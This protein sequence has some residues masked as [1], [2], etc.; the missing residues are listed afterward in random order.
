MDDGTGGGLALIPE[1]APFDEREA[2]VA[3]PPAVSKVL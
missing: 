2:G 1:E 3:T